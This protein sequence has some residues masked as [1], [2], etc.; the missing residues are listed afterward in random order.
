MNIDATGEQS[1]VI[2]GA[3]LAGGNAAANP[4]SGILSWLLGTSVHKRAVWTSPIS[5]FFHFTLVKYIEL[6]GN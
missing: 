1:V 2:V 6:L 5:F 4:T 3:G